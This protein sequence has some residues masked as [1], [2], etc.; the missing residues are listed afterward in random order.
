MD[1]ETPTAAPKTTDLKSGA[2]VVADFVATIG[3]DANLDK[4]TVQA[5]S[6]LYPS[7]FTMNNLVRALELA[8]IERKA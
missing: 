8:R 4:D 6:S 5:I 2:Q 7:K 1:R 3:R